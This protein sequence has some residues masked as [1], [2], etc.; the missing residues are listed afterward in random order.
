MI[1]DGGTIVSIPNAAF[2]AVKKDLSGSSVVFIAWI[3]DS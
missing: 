1:A 3:V 2:P